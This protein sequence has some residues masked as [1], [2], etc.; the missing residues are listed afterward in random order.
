MSESTHPSVLPSS[1][2]QL[3]SN[4]IIFRYDTLPI[5]VPFLYSLRQHS[6]TSF[7]FL[8]EHVSMPR[9]A[10]RNVPCYSIFSFKYTFPGQILYG[11]QY[12]RFRA[13]SLPSEFVSVYVSM[14]I[15]FPKVPFP[16]SF[17]LPAPYISINFFEFSFGSSWAFFSQTTAESLQNVS[18]R[19]HTFSVD[20]HVLLVEHDP[21]RVR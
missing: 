16:E 5:I 13:W 21:Y 3:S 20:D 14:S 18:G 11:L 19:N 7:N 1:T 8:N 12:V 2:L 15:V 9:V 6:S 4:R 17:P 10:L